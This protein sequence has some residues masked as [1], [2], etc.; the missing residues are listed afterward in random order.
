MIPTTRTVSALFV[1]I[2]VLAPTI[3]ADAEAPAT[4]QEMIDKIASKEFA[5]NVSDQ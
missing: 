4:L 3:N 2:A 5:N 1:V